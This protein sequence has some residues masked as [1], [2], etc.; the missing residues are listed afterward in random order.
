[1]KSDAT[2]E[3]DLNA[4]ETNDNNNFTIDKY[5]QIRVGEV[6]YPSPLPAG[7]IGPGTAM[8]SHYGRPGSWTSRA[9]TPSLSWSLGPPIQEDPI[10]GRPGPGVTIRLKDLNERPYFDEQSRVAVG[11]PRLYAETRTNMI[12]TLAAM[13]NPTGTI[14]RW[15]V[16]GVDAADFMNCRRP[17]TLPAT[18]KTGVELH[19]KSQPNYEKST[20]MMAPAIADRDLE[21]QDGDIEDAGEGIITGGDRMYE[22]TVRATETTRPSAWRSEHG[23]GIA[24][25]RSRSS[26]RMRTGMVE[27]N[28]LQ[29]EVG[30]RDNRQ[31]VTDPGRR[32]PTNTPMWTWYRSK[33]KKP[34][35]NPPTDDTEPLH[36]TAEWE[37]ITN[38][39][40]P[41]NCEP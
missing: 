9:P 34:N 7:I 25:Y 33:V 5:G 11:A 18:A 31:P 14:L 32:R 37:M 20:D 1:M 10:P 22:V 3:Y 15:E 4:T 28:W 39:T 35:P 2:L 24:R 26:T 23:G 29:P 12:V 30:T 19:F 38:L 36:F 16:T 8:A 17:R 27:L 21:H 13:Q 40:V 41:D 6:E